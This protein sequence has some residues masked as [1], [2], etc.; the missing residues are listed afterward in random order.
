MQLH[1]AVFANARHS[2]WLDEW[3]GH[4]G[5]RGDLVLHTRIWATTD[6]VQ[7]LPEQCTRVTGEDILAT[8]SSHAPAP[9]TP[10][11]AI[12]VLVNGDTLPWARE[13]VEKL[14]PGGKPIGLVTRSV[15]PAF[16]RGLLARGAQDFIAWD[17]QREELLL[18][19]WKLAASAAAS[20]LAHPASAP[21]PPARH[22]KLAGLI[23]E[24]PAF[25]AQL[26]CMPRFAECDAGVL[27]LG[28]TGTGKELVAQA[29]HY[30]SPRA[31]QSFVAINCGALP[32]DLVEA[33]LF[34][35]ARGAFTNAHE[36]RIGLVAQAEGGTL[37]LDEVDSL[38]PLAQVKLL[39]FL[40][41]KEY[42]AV[43]SNRV[44]CADVR[45]ISASNGDLHGLCKRGAFRTDLYYRLNVLNLTLPA[46]RE[47]GDDVIALAQ[48]FVKRFAR[49]FR[50]P[51]EGLAPDACAQLRAHAWPGNVRELEHTIERGVLLA[52]GNTLRAADLDLP[53]PP[54]G[55]LDAE[56]FQAAKARAV[57]Q[58]ER[59][60][61]E[62]ALAQCDGNITHA[63]ERV[64]KN[65][66]AFF[67]LMRKYGIESRVYRSPE[68]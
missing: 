52:T 1:L 64:A 17:C 56:S 61:I 30:L 45:V 62:V 16:V 14:R 67:E 41:D 4:A 6:S 2:H 68:T 50:R 31:S 8:P 55:S 63:A 7:L 54:A 59:H 47:R 21:V 12:V 65:R 60:Y 23:G 39:R 5:Q 11:D 46:L 53:Q 26:D 25:A 44:Q 19:L 15:K 29:M 37:F 34:G 35:H 27:I 38:P 42:R 51:V 49:Q 33:E 28:E 22:P 18:R 13:L 57:E 10:T 40:Q 48:H 58:F 36:T 20:R 43:G 32:A 24:S 9:E 3:V 66:R